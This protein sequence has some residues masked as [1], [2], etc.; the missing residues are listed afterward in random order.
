MLLQL[1]ATHP[2][3]AGD[4][5]FVLETRVLPLPRGDDAFADLRRSFAGLLAGHFSEF[6]RRHLDMQIY[7]VEQRAGCDAGHA[8]GW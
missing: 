6:H 7:A 4:F 3:V 2:R 5:G 8:S 1:A